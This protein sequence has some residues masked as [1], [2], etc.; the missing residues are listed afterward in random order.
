MITKTPQKKS[1][2]FLINDQKPTQRQGLFLTTLRE[3]GPTP[4]LFLRQEIPKGAD[5]VVRSESQGMTVFTVKIVSG[6]GGGK[7]Y[8]KKLKPT[9]DKMKGSIGIIYA[10]HLEHLLFLKSNKFGNAK[11]IYDVTEKSAPEKDLKVDFLSKAAGDLVRVFEQKTAKSVGLHGALFDGAMQGN[12][13]KYAG[14]CPRS[15]AILTAPAAAN[16]SGEEDKAKARENLK[17]KRVVAVLGDFS[18]WNEMSSALEV[19][20]NVSSCNDDVFFLFIGKTGLDRAALKETIRERELTGRAVFLEGLPYG[21]MLAYMENADIGLVLSGVG[22]GFDAQSRRLF[23]CMHAGLPV[24]APSS[25][26]SAV[27]VREANCG[28]LVDAKSSVDIATGVSYM[29]ANPDKAKASGEKGREAFISRY[30][31]EM[32]QKK[33]IALFE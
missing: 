14:F 27:V 7:R 30:C 12:R 2:I 31:W 8:C 15:E 17:G 23:S 3:A 13:E 18:D 29:L 1:I 10:A 33:L 5:A 32:E 16:T 28:L 6:K 11:I 9:L 24:V 20:E 22:A 4:I 19:A 26:E 25:C 21:K